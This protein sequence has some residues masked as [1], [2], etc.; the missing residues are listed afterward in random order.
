MTI[1]SRKFLSLA[2]S[3]LL[4]AALLFWMYN[5]LAD[6]FGAIAENHYKKAAEVAMGSVPAKDEAIGGW[7]RRISGPSREFD[8]LFLKGFPE[9]KGGVKVFAPTPALGDFLALNG[10]DPDF[11]RGIESA[12]YDEIYQPARRFLLGDEERRVL[13]APAHD[14]ETGEVTG[15][16]VFLFSPGGFD[17]FLSLLRGLFL[18]A[19]VLFAAVFAVAS[20]SRDPITGYVILGLFTI[21]G[22]F[23]AYP[24]FEAVRLTFLENGRF[25]LETWKAVLTTRQYV[26]ALKGSVTLG[27]FTA[28]AST[29]IGFLFAFVISRTKVRGKKF[30]SAM[31]TLPIISPPFSLTLSIILLFGN[32]GLITKQIL[33]LEN[34]TIYGLGGLTLVQTMGMF[35]IAFLTMVG[36]LEAIDSTLEDAA[37]NLRA[38]RWETFKT[39]T[40]PLSVP[41]LLSSWLLVFTNSLA[42]FANPLLL[43]GDYRVLSL[44]PICW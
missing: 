29:V 5:A 17:R 12:M 28:T 35:P 19:L 24:L 22:V 42:D 43:S 39:V 25:T 32:N 30:F 16:A 44:K 2:L 18:L 31:A 14:G 6:S 38:T 1:P 8:L 33:G 41:G 21:V 13:F 34:F 20:Y 27:A 36:I 3:V 26:T 10:K 7:I 23:V 9:D 15:T 11:A 37:L 4:F 40:L